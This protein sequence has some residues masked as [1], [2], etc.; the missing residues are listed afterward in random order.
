MERNTCA[1]GG[2]AGFSLI[3][4]LVASAI[5]GILAG[6]AVEAFSVY[7]DK[8]YYSIS[9]QVLV[10]ARTSLEAGLID[11]AD[12][13]GWHSIWQNTP[14]PPTTET[15]Q[16][17]APGLVVP[18]DSIV[19]VRHRSD[20]GN[21]E[22]CIEDYAYVRHCKADEYTYWYRYR[23]GREWTARGVDATGWDC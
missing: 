20:C 11:V 4:L 10:Q 3:E 14:G 12:L 7:R 22:W 2:E 18:V 15:G 5:M 23:N 8:S 16:R 19:Y 13:D 21:E 6:L 17:L 9:E 1:L